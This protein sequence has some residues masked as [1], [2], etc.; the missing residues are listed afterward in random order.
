MFSSDTLHGPLTADIENRHVG[1]LGNILTD[2]DGGADIDITD[3]IIQLYNATQ[4]ILGRTVVV[5]LLEDDGGKGGQPDSNTTG[6][7]FV[8]LLVILFVV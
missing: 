7:D 8:L 1:D 2:T 4:S 5:H 6:Y 3:D